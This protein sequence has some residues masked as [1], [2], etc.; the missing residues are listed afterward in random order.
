[1][2]KV[3]LGSIC[4][5]HS[6]P[7]HSFPV[8]WLSPQS[9]LVPVSCR[10]VVLY[11]L[12]TILSDPI[13]FFPCS[14]LL[15]RVPSPVPSISVAPIDS[16][17]C[18][19]S[20]FPLVVWSFFIINLVPNLFCISRVV[21][22]AIHPFCP[23]PFPSHPS[24]FS[25]SPSLPVLLFS[26]LFNSIIFA[27]TTQT[28]RNIAIFFIAA[29]AYFESIHHQKCINFCAALFSLISSPPITCNPP[30]PSLNAARVCTICSTLPALLCL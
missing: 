4:Q 8:P 19:F 10:V 30:A 9:L 5:S 6:F 27:H 13:S 12:S 22:I 16:S 25:P 24:P 18:L 23:L 21:P 26:P 29:P 1:M 2:V 17:F 15:F 20:P 3:S 11:L 14:L 7:L 28:R